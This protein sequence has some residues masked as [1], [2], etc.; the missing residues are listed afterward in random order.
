MLFWRFKATKL[1]LK[2]HSYGIQ[3]KAISTHNK[4]MKSY[5]EKIIRKLRMQ[6]ISKAMCDEIV[7]FSSAGSIEYAESLLIGEEGHESVEDAES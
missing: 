5:E 4:H 2:S 6:G 7:K 1:A 3:F